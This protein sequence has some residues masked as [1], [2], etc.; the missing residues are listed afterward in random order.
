MRFV[1]IVPVMAHVNDSWVRGFGGLF[2]LVD[3]LLPKLVEAITIICS[4]CVLR[5]Q[6]YVGCMGCGAAF[7]PLGTGGPSGK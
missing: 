7:W 2:M 6:V 4:C 1:R 3:V 5:A